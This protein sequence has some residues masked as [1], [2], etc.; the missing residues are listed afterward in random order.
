M[1]RAPLATDTRR[2][3]DLPI[4]GKSHEAYLPSYHLPWP[5]PS[6]TLSALRILSLKPLGAHCALQGRLVAPSI[7]PCPMLSV[8]LE[9]VAW[10]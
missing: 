2:C 5:L 10:V 9:I 4:L 3:S 6:P 7:R 1:S 8:V